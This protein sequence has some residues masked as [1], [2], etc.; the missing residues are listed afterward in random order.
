MMTRS[1]RTVPMHLTENTFEVAE[2]GDLLMV[3]FSADWCP[4]C[5]AMTPVLEDLAA[6]SGDR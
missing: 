1:N 2:N 4:P 5:N 3:D 6:N